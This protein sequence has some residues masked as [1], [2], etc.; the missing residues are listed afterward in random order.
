MDV[1]IKLGLALALTAPQARFRLE[2]LGRFG[3]K[4]LLYMKYITL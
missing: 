3:R 4:A 2:A 1:F